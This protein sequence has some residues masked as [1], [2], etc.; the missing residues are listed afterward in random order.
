MKKIKAA[1]RS[2]S[3]FTRKHHT[4]IDDPGPSVPLRGEVGDSR[5][6]PTWSLDNVDFL[7][8]LRVFYS[9]FNPEK[10]STIEYIYEQYKGDEMVLIYQLAEKYELTHDAMQAIINSSCDYQP[11]CDI[12]ESTASEVIDS[13]AGPHPPFVTSPTPSWKPK[14]DERKSLH[15]TQSVRQ[16][17]REN[18]NVDLKQFRQSHNASPQNISGGVVDTES[19]ENDDSKNSVAPTSLQD[20]INSS[21]RS[22]SL[23]KKTVRFSQNVT[24][25]GSSVDSN[26][27]T[28]LP[29][30]SSD[31]SITTFSSSVS[32]V[33]RPNLVM[34]TEN[35][36]TTPTYTKDQYS[37]ARTPVVTSNGTARDTSSHDKQRTARRSM[38]LVASSSD[39]NQQQSPSLNH[40]ASTPKLYAA[41]TRDS[42]FSNQESFDHHS[43]PE[44]GPQQDKINPEQPVSENLSEPAES[45]GDREFNGSG[46]RI[47]SV[48]LEEMRL[49]LERTRQALSEA[50][51]ERDT[52]L[53]LLQE[54]A[55]SPEEMKGVVEAYLLKYGKRVEERSTH[56]RSPT[57]ILRHDGDLN[58]LQLR[59][60]DLEGKKVN[61][62]KVPV[63]ERPTGAALRSNS[64]SSRPN[65]EKSYMSGTASSS[66]RSMELALAGNLSGNY[67]SLSAG[68]RDPSPNGSVCSSR[69]RTVSRNRGERWIRPSSADRTRERSRSPASSEPRRRSSRS[70]SP[71][72][73]SEDLDSQYHRSKKLS[74]RSGNQMRSFR[75]TSDSEY[76]YRPQGSTSRLGAASPRRGT[77]QSGDDWV[78]C[79]DPKTGK[80]YYYSASRKKSVWAPPVTLS[81]GS[82]SSTPTGSRASTP[83]GGSR[84]SSREG[85]VTFASTPVSRQQRAASPAGSN[86]SQRSGGS[87]SN[88][89]AKAIDRKTGKTYWYNRTT[90][91]STWKRPTEANF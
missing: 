29:R 35:G 74:D 22:D 87:S 79:V 90:G 71:S 75:N 17:A 1:V 52:V 89:W 73:N 80:T 25:E 76:Q 5:N 65:R 38:A 40:D 21:R 12:S 15:D 37:P 43:M 59:L 55:S 14:N 44:R 58:R 8:F 39:Y 85:R 66:K 28:S 13:S 46:E 49:E 86:S 84:S 77:Q 62:S 78:A 64:T 4:D 34:K 6:R 50:D 53:H 81:S 83:A 41:P 42:R 54:M 26:T 51:K 72:I 69:G 23:S 91:V 24:N 60:R 31:A 56:G 11:D 45:I 7:K 2:I 32:G 63:R 36:H 33:P 48:H 70:P 18:Q 82:R 16:G 20:I 30:Q 68:S 57:G 88:Q 61:P 67:T 3:P 47:Q 19:S 10:L 27:G 9:K